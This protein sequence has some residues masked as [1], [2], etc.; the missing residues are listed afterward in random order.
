MEVW[1]TQAQIIFPFQL[2]TGHMPFPDYTDHDVFLMVPKGKRPL[3]PSRFEA[4]GMTADVWRVAEKCWSK[5]A[6]E[7]PDANIVLQCF[8]GLNRTGGCTHEA[9]SCLPWELIDE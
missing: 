3:K 6:E 1:N 2:A 9:G 4:P 5:K 8:Q 7:R